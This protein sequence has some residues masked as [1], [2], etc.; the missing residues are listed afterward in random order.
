MNACRYSAVTDGTSARIGSQPL[1]YHCHPHPLTYH[2]HTHPLTYHCHTHPLTYHCHT[3]SPVACGQFSRVVVNRFQPPK[4]IFFHP[5]GLFFFLSSFLARTTPPDDDRCDIHG[6]TFEI[7]DMG[8]NRT[9]SSS[10]WQKWGTDT[11]AV[12]FVV[13]LT[14]YCDNVNDSKNGKNKMVRGDVC[15]L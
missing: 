5:T 14:D 8:Y 3:H 10:R 4:L 1:T 6:S 12:L 13:D 2:C 7:Y 15:V 11:K 9:T